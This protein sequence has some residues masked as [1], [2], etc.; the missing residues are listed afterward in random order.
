MIAMLRK[1]LP[2]AC[3]LSWLGIGG[4][5]GGALVE[6][7]GVS[8]QAPAMLRGYL[9]RPDAGMSAIL[10][11][12]SDGAGRYGAL[13]VLHGCSGLSSHSVAIA[14]RVGSWG[15]AALAVDSLGPRGIAGRCG[16]GSSR[17][18]AFDAYAALR[19]LSR[20]QFVDPA[21]VAVLGQ[22]MGGIAVLYAVDRDLAAQYFKERFRAAIA[23]YPS[24]AI[25]APRMT[26][27]TLILKGEADEW[28][29][30]ENCQA[31]VE[32]ARPEGAPITLTVY[33]GVHH[34][35]DVAG[36]KPGIRYLGRWIEYN[37]AAARDAEEKARSF[38][39]AN[40]GN[41]TAKKPAA[42]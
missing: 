11:G 37:E 40:L 18:Q 13:V 38:L 21:R 36:L 26:A 5:S 7:P 23:Y 9:A 8:D 25:P 34:A 35:F 32:H 20:L 42:Q 6:F 41:P 33:P 31:M 16:G 17:D 10:G 19:Y 12:Q 14:D 2:A 39:A 27:P 1:V 29:P 3:L 24:C 15:Y 4:A 30:R 22:S 28:S